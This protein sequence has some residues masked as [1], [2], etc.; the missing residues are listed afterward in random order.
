LM[1]FFTARHSRNPLD[2]W[3]FSG[4]PLLRLLKVDIYPFIRAFVD[5]KPILSRV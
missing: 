5:T 3:Q 4:L 1:W 2:N